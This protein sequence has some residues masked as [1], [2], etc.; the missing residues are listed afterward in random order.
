MNA[1]LSVIVM[2][3]NEN[4]IW[5]EWYTHYK[6]EG[7]DNF[8]VINHNS[9][10]PISSTDNVQVF[11]WTKNATIGRSNQAEA[12][13]SIMSKIDSNWTL[14]VDA[15]E[16]VFGINHTLRRVLHD[17]PSHI[18]QVCIPWLVFTSSGLEK[19][20][21]C[22][23]KSCI[24]RHVHLKSI[25]KCATRRHELQRIEIHRSMLIG[26]FY[27]RR[28]NSRCMCPDRSRCRSHPYPSFACGHSNLTKSIVRIHHYQSQSHEDILRKSRMQDADLKKNKRSHAYWRA[29]E[30][31]NVSIDTT[32]SKKSACKVT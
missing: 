14:V 20:P 25:G 1:F 13:N 3:K 32:L 5:D 12:Y 19:H 30:T 23:T 21:K 11:E 29:I 15:D 26:E 18:H 6:Q 27:H 9:Q 31:A 17:T 22:V 4:A 10:H 8:Y 28:N 2:M 7:V 24:Y 16:F